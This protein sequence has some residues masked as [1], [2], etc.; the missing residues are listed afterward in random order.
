V[1]TVAR[2]GSYRIERVFEGHRDQYVIATKFARRLEPTAEL[3]EV[4]GERYDERG[5]ARQ[6]LAPSGWGR[7]V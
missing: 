2:W 3:P 4:A 1:S 7:T 6:S 5:M